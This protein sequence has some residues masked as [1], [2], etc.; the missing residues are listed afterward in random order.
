MFFGSI[1]LSLRAHVFLLCPRGLADFVG[2]M[3]PFLIWSTDP[4]N[5]CRVG[6]CPRLDGGGYLYFEIAAACNL[7]DA[8]FLGADGGF[9]ANIDDF[10][11]DA[12]ILLFNQ[13][14]L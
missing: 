13:R 12:G 14:E 4:N 3:N 8:Q 11:R 9:M 7:T 6:L 5:Q 10:F 2:T 1:R